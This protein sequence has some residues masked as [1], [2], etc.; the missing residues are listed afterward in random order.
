MELRKY[1]MRS[2]AAACIFAAGS[3]GSVATAQ[4]SANQNAV[5]AGPA[6]NRGAM[7]ADKTD[8]I[9][10]INEANRVIEE[11][12]REPQARQLLQEANGVF[13]VSRYA[14]AGFGVG[15]RGGEGVL[16]VKQNGD[17]SNP[18]FY[19]FGGVSGGFLAGAEAGSLVMVLNNQKAVQSFMQSN[20]WSLNADAGL[21]V[22][23]WSEKAKGELGMGD[24]VVW[25]NA[26]GLMAD[27]SASVTDIQF[28]GEE[29]SAFYGRQ[30]A[31]REVFNTNMQAQPHVANLKQ[32]LSGRTAQSTGGSGDATASDPTV[33]IVPVVP[34]VPVEPASE[35]MGSSGTESGAT[36]TS[37]DSMEQRQDM[38]GQGT[39][40]T[41]GEGGT[42]ATSSTGSTG[43]METGEK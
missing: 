10:Q 2:I 15:V 31:L 34:V 13:V 20:N 12:R 27:V 30:I 3:I 18:A 22:V 6:D 29:T 43:G 41:S 42:G 7:I 32:T 9:A 37:G 39:G 38:S 25:S 21:T 1:Q 36:G 23:S 4:T 26:Q 11:M 17:W 24:I 14:R 16:L 19:N 40:G 35:A 28:D 33:T 8:A 5:V